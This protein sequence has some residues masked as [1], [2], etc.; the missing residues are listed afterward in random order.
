MGASAG[1][2]L[3][4]LA[5]PRNFSSVV[6]AM[7]GRHPQL[8]DAP[9]TNLFTGGRYADLDR[10]Y[11]IQPRFQHGLLRVVAELGMGGQSEAQVE[12]A[13]GWLNERREAP[14][15]EIFRQLMVWAA[16]RRLV[17]KS[18]IY[19]LSP[20]AFE[21]IRAAFPV[22]FYLHL[23]RHPRSACESIHETRQSG[24]PAGGQGGGRFPGARD[25]GRKLGADS[26]V[27]PENMW[28]LPHLK[29]LEALDG[30]AEDRQ[31]RVRGED[32]LGAPQSVLPSLCAWLGI[33]QAPEDIEA[34]CHP[35]DSPFAHFGPANA[36]LG[37][38]RHFM[39]SPQLRPPAPVSADLT[40][41]LS[42]DAGLR[43]GDEVRELAH[44]FGY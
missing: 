41:P 35:E 2:P 43:F 34:M 30:V 1:E 19:V 18:P 15:A 23:T 26:E 21:R 25:M 7:L 12:A 20:G 16:P 37:N 3:F 40:A 24:H 10:V 9:E 22:A 28:L 13:R 14:T 6:C 8:F 4:I 36:P 32:L 27:T 42:W 39:E 11:A 33:S 38:D 5:P 17:E 44:R 29:I 31:Y